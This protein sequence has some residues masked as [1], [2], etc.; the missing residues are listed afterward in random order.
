MC[1]LLGT[2][3]RRKRRISRT[4]VPSSQHS[5]M[6][7]GIV[8]ELNADSPLRARLK[9]ARLVDEGTGSTFTALAERKYILL[10]YR[11]VV[12]GDLFT[13][14]QI[15]PAGRKL[16]RQATSEQREKPLPAG[17]LREWHWKAMALAWASR[18]AGVKMKMATM[19]TSRGRP[20]SGSA[21][22]KQPTKRSP[23]SRNI[24]RVAACI[25]R[26]QDTLLM[27]V[28]FA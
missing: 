22:I 8:P 3:V 24:E 19:D 28:G 2:S 13:Y 27:F 6:Y 17:T 18:P 23:W 16:V 1:W 11:P 10:Q 21:T 9:S 26:Q 7:Y 15:T 4:D 25:I 14:V 12:G 20:G 5:W